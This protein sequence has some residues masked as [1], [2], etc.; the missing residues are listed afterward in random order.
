MDVAA[1]FDI[2]KTNKKFFLFGQDNGLLHEEHRHFD[3][4]TD[5][6]GEACDDLPAIAHWMRA[7][8]AHA[9]KGDFGQRIKALNFSAF[10][11]SL[12]H[13]DR[14]GNPLTPLYSY[15]KPLPP[16]IGEQFYNAWGGEETLAAETASPV[17]GMLNSGLQ[18]YWLK[19]ARPSVFRQVR[20]MLHLPQYFAYLFTKKP[21]SGICSIGCHTHLWDFKKQ[22]YHAW[23]EKEGL[24]PLF[25]G[26]EAKD[27]GHPLEA[28]PAGVLAG[29][30]LH[31]SSSALVPYL[32]TFETPF[33][34]VSTGTWSISL[35]PFNHDPLT[36]SELKKD[37]LCYLSHEGRPVK[38]SRLFLG[39]EH[40]LET[41]RIASEF[42]V[43]PGFY[44]AVSP[45]A[46]L[47]RKLVAQAR[48]AAAFV[49]Q[50]ATGFAPIGDGGSQPSGEPPFSGPAEA[51]HQLVFG[52]VAKQAVST[53]LV[54]G[55]RPVETIFV[56]GG[57][58][59]NPLYMQFLATAFPK[60]KVCAAHLNQAS[61]LGAALAIAHAWNPQGSVNSSL[62]N[63]VQYAPVAA[64][65]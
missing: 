52:L 14:A 46:G 35:N 19:Q 10:G 33:V 24:L 59:H 13:L 26:I 6:D 4:T 36:A 28:G 29:N 2:G 48:Q 30:G 51:Y 44:K 7:T 57:F 49:P 25:P 15:L 63:L 31:D 11:A 58:A 32:K 17:L 9:L 39:H 40:D 22:G 23:V 45:D 43:Q 56:D 64:F 37:C 27:R 38:A 16:G 5:E 41:A 55:S 54:M 12:V 61:A 8:F 42:N 50:A 21:S 53:A 20:H 3:E 18:A 1:V 60:H 65:S 47:V 62:F 34:L